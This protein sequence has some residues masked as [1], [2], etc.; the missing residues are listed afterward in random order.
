MLQ[1]KSFFTN[2]YCKNTENNRKD[3]YSVF[4]SLDPW[5]NVKGDAKEYTDEDEDIIIILTAK[6]TAYEFYFSDILDDCREIEYDEEKSE[7]KD[8]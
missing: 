5:Y 8:V 2:T 7:W 4:S 6:K 3:I 1:D